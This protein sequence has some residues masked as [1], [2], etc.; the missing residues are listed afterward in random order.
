MIL[1]ELAVDAGEFA[2]RTGWVAK[3]EGMCKGPVCVPLPGGTSERLDATTLSERL[4]MAMV[5]DDD[6]DLWALGPATVTGKALT[7]AE[8]PELVLPDLRT[9][10]A[11]DVA[12]LRGHKV[13]LVAWASW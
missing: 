10:E 6:H 4:G 1:T 2:A 13:L 12:S 9:S 11:F 5:R 7:T 3:P 8:M